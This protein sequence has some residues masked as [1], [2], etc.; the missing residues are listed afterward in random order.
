MSQKYRALLPASNCCVKLP[1]FNRHP[2][3][4]IQHL[5]SSGLVEKTPAAVAQFLRD[6]PNLDKVGSCYSFGIC[7]YMG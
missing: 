2:G 3:K 4:G 6:T 1:Q 7:G 5:I